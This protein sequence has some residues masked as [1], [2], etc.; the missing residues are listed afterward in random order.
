M[1]DGSDQRANAEENM[2]EDPEEFFHALVRGDI[3][4]VPPP[5][6]DLDGG[7]DLDDETVNSWMNPDGDGMEIDLLNEGQTNNDDEGRQLQTNTDG[8]VYIH[9]YWASRTVRFQY[10][11]IY[12][13]TTLFFLFLALRIGQIVVICN[14]ARPDQETGS[15]SKVKHRGDRCKWPTAAARRARGYIRKSVRSAC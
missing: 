1:D 4:Y 9:I 13:L 12:L 14:E 6:E 15:Q 8:E 5:G 3:A 10:A 7:V 11:R 2:A